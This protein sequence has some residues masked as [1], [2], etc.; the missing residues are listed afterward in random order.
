MVRRSLRVG[1]AVNNRVAPT[2]R[3]ARLRGTPA[4]ACRPWEVVL[5]SIANWASSG[6]EDAPASQL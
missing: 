3:M 2:P 4:P 6:R 1:T 5:S